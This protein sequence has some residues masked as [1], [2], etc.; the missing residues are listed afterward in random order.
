M[1]IG[2]VGAGFTGC[3]AARELAQAGHKCTVY[4]SRAHIGGNCFTYLDD[5]TGINIH[6]YGP[7]IF[8]TDNE[9][10][11]DYVRQFSAFEP[12]TNRVKSTYNG[13]VYSLPVNLHTINQYFKKCLSPSEAKDFISSIS[14]KIDDPKNF[15]EQA[16]SMIGRD[17]YEAFFK[18]YTLKQW[19]VEPAS[20]PA[21][22]LKRL[23]VRFNYDDNYF[24]HKYQGMP[25]HGYTPIFEKL[26]DHPSIETYL[27]TQFTSKDRI[28]HDHII[29]TGPLDAWFE[30]RLGRLGY[31]TLRFEKSVYEGDFQGCAVM[32]YGDQS[33]PYTR[34]SEHK[35]F[36]PWENHDKTVVFKEF[37][38]FCKDGDIPYYPIRLAA[39]K[40]LLSKYINAAKNEEGVT[41]AGRLGSYRYLDMDQTIAEALDLSNVIIDKLKNKAQIP[42]FVI[43]PA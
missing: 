3:V 1:N 19:G 6:K 42:S 5:E 16:I 28:K 11:W 26:L 31:R 15:E 9:K 13:N 32:N 41:F 39:D 12:F 22:I 33:V 40:E 34:I 4:E 27:N 30:H 21:S 14:E 36:A 24:N 2:I 37:S 29:W 25:T 43:D 23:P 35:H 20:L 8:H 10:V 18:G 7:H 38:S 17:L